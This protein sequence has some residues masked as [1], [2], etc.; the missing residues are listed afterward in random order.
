MATWRLSRYA[1]GHSNLGIPMPFVLLSLLL[2]A[3]A[4]NYAPTGGDEIVV[5]GHKIDQ[6]TGR[7]EIHGTRRK[8]STKTSSGDPQIDQVGCQAFLSCADRYQPETDE[9]D[10]KGIDRQTR[11][12][13]KETL[14]AH[15]RAC[16]ADQRT[17]LLTQLHEHRR[18]TS[19]R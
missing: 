11:Q 6:W 18:G 2:A 15:M 1:G 12:A 19:S 3:P 14:I 13:R 16:I 8:C 9:S 7:F 5:M 17:I 4:V 10:E